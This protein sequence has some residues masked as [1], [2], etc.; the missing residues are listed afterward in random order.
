MLLMGFSPRLSSASPPRRDRPT[1]ARQALYEL[2]KKTFVHRV[3]RAARGF[4]YNAAAC[5]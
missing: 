2:H 5:S 1:K 3:L 4:A